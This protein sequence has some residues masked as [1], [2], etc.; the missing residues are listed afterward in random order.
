[1][2]ELL[3][4][5]ALGVTSCPA[6]FAAWIQPSSDICIFSSQQLKKFSTP[7]LIAG[8]WYLDC[9][10]SF[11][12]DEE[13]E[14]RR[15][16]EVNSPISLDLVG[17]DDVVI[18]DNPVPPPTT[19]EEG[20]STKKKL[21]KKA[22]KV[23]LEKEKAAKD[24]AEKVAAIERGVAEA[25][26]MAAV[27][28]PIPWSSLCNAREPNVTGYSSPVMDSQAAGSSY[29]QTSWN[30][31]AQRKA[32]Q[33]TASGSSAPPPT[34]PSESFIQHASVFNIMDS[35]EL[36]GGP[37]PLWASLHNFISQVFYSSYSSFLLFLI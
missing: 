15:T 23:K 5:N 19:A 20:T 33:P 18:L 4:K 10:L 12:P 11:T 24:A 25:L 21:T 9:P 34:V 16:L 26:K 8:G 14:L 2:R 13:V 28:N 31:A 29:I 6:F 3:P 22:E 32:R 30:V 37:H 36:P 1:M 17:E 27:Q 7:H 35:L